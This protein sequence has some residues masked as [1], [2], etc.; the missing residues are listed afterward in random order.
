MTDAV[1]IIDAD[2]VVRDTMTQLLHLEGFAPFTT[3]NG[4]EALEFLRA[5]GPTKIILLDLRMPMVDG[6]TL[7]PAHRPNLEMPVVVLKKTGGGHALA[8]AAS[9][10]KPLDFTRVVEVVRDLCR[11]QGAAGG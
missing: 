8:V 6:W 2:P 10:T 5:G 11:N 4:H 9:F 3:A 1:L 7:S